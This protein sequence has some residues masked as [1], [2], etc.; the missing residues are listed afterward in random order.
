MYTVRRKTFSDGATVTAT[1]AH[2]YIYVANPDEMQGDKPI[3]EEE[4]FLCFKEP[5]LA[6]ANTKEGRELLDID[7]YNDRPFPV[8]DIT[9]YSVIF[10]A[11]KVLGPRVRVGNFSGAPHWGNVIR[12]RWLEV[13]AALNRITLLEILE[14]PRLIVTRSGKLLPVL[15]GAASITVYGAT[16]NSVGFDGTMALDYHGDGSSSYSSPSSWGKAWSWFTGWTTNETDQSSNSTTST[17]T[18]YITGNYYSTWHQGCKVFNSYLDGK[19][20]SW[21]QAGNPGST[22][23]SYNNSELDRSMFSFNTSAIG[24]TSTVTAATLYLYTFSKNRSSSTWD[25]R[26]GNPKACVYGFDPDSTSYVACKDWD[27][28]AS[29][30]FASEKSY[31][32]ISTGSHH[33]Y[34][35][36][37][38][39]YL[40]GMNKTGPSIFGIRLTADAVNVKPTFYNEGQNNENQYWTSEGTYVTTRFIDGPTA[41]QKPYLTVTYTLPTTA[42]VTGEIGNGATE[43]AVRSAT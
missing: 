17:G 15:A 7:R 39:G 36:N 29:T 10:D 31:T 28:Y 35:F 24:S 43:Q 40:S 12:E 37:S 32:S 20:F 33:N 3:D 18:T 34:A 27:E 22:G 25:S 30:K 19:L 9:P 21:H 11:S 2:P 13:K 16:G 41:S 38:S 5:L 14:M 42:A 1:T 8:A 26:Y 4:W 6:L 23:P